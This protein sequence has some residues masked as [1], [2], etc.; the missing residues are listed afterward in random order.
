MPW[1][2]A[3]FLTRSTLSLPPAAATATFTA[4]MRASS[5]EH[6]ASKE[7][8]WTNYQRP[9]LFDGQRPLLLL[10]FQLRYFFIA[11][12]ITNEATLTAMSGTWYNPTAT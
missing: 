5:V 8:W 3:C 9:L 12:T 10:L 4:F 2:K 7:T 1:I 6:L 11:V